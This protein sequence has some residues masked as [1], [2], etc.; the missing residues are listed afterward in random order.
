M[1]PTKVLFLN[2]LGIIGGQEVVMLDIVRNLDRQRYSALA[3]MLVGGPLVD[4]LGTLGVR[5]HILPPHRL[6]QP[7]RLAL[8]IR[9]LSRL[10]AREHVDIVHCNGDSLLL[11]GALA[12]L[13]NRI[14]CIWHVY[15]PVAYRGSAYVRLLYETQR[16][17]H[18]AWTIFGTAA[19]EDSYLSHYPTLGP[20]TPIMPGVDVAALTEGADAER[21]RQKLG[22]PP[23]APLLLMIGRLQRSKGQRELIEAL[24]LL[25]GARPEPHVVLC[26][27]PPV[28]TDEGYEAELTEVARAN[29]VAARVHFT[30]HV[31]DAEKKDLLAAATLLVHPT[32][33]EAFGIAV[34]EGMAAGK[35]VVVTDSVGPK[36]IVEGS[37][38][39][40]IVA[41]RSVPE[42]AAAIR[43]R[44]DDPEGS[45]RMGALGRERVLERYSTQAMVGKVEQVYRAVLDA[46]G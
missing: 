39:G 10:I 5:T 45:R 25:S 43:R 34:I 27:G 15:E 23:D 21:A 33:R 16:R 13:F 4:A 31:S 46:P 32:H 18:P 28:M 3:A 38:A 17:L 9:S 8:A 1:R 14:P 20:H 11:Y 6:R 37:G 24:A 40:E 29:G 41:R 30:G 19:V 35:A 36:S 2:T 12:V 7:L 26:G 42:L 44:L 22:L